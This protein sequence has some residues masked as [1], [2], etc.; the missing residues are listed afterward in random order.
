VKRGVHARLSENY[1]G[2][3]FSKG[4][5][6]VS[7]WKKLRREGVKKSKL[8]RFFKMIPRGGLHFEDAIGEHG[9][10]GERVGRTFYKM[11]PRGCIL[12]GS[13]GNPP[14]VN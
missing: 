14:R 9:E 1:W 5:P 2:M 11:T 10:P 3:T 4:P 8:A 12:K 13:V 6:G 7:F